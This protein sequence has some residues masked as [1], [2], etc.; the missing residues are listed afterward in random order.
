MAEK[1]A[2]KV[3]ID[4]ELVNW[5]DATIH[6]I[7]HVVHYGSSVFEGIRCY[8]VGGTPK[9]FH[10]HAHVDRLF[11]SAKIYRMEIPFSKDEIKQAMLDTIKAN[12]FQECYV[13]PVF[14]RDQGALGV[15][16]FPAEVK[17]VIL[18][19]KWGAYL[20]K[21]ALEE[22]VDICVSTW[23]RM[24][25][26]THAGIAKAGGNYL[27]S[28]LMK[29]EALTNGYVE[30][31][32]LQ[33]NG[34]IAEGSG[35]NL[36]MIAKRWGDKHSTIF[37]PPLSASILSGITRAT[38]IQLASELGMTVVEQTLPREALYVCDE[39]FFT[40]TAA[41]ITPIRTVDRLPI[42]TGRRG[43]VTKQLQEALFAILTGKVEDRHGWLTPVE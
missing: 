27:N 39:L 36:F 38:V 17:C 37:T 16:P 18:T 40:G 11:D 9:I 10:L 21:E 20:G 2:D 29:M 19:W 33:T 35:E 34:Y 14:F 25:A 13:R 31:I 24:H 43:P 4:G 12:G 22:G 30:A 7:S 5:E 8:D 23:S 1:L 28:Q 26:N 41:E 15:N 42:G 6:V 3:W 32:A